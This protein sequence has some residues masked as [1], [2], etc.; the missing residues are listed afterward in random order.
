[1]YFVQKM[2]F[3]SRFLAYVKEYWIQQ[4]SPLL[5]SVHGH[6]RRT[7]NGVES[8]HSQLN[9]A[10]GVPHPNFW[11]FLGKV[12]HIYPDFIPPSSSY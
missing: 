4:R 1:M 9:K 10:V 5:V 12:F 7:N 8:F 11:I 3:P 6:P 2:L